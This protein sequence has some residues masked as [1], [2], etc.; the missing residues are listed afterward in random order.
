M[1]P[2]SGGALSRSH[3]LS[4]CAETVVTARQGETRLGRRSDDSDVA[5]QWRPGIRPPVLSDSSIGSRSFLCNQSLAGTHAR[6]GV[7]QISAHGR[8]GSS[9]QGSHRSRYRQRY[10][11][12]MPAIGA[13]KFLSGSFEVRVSKPLLQRIAVRA[14]VGS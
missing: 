11:K 12:F 10:E 2:E 4:R 1:A 13:K 6:T 5:G 8:G 9:R 14:L 3:S 7:E